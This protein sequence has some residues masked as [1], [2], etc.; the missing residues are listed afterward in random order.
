MSDNAPAFPPPRI[1]QPEECQPFDTAFRPARV[2]HI[3]DADT[4]DLSIDLGHDRAGEKVRIRL[5]GEAWLKD[6]RIGFNAWESRGD[7]RERGLLAKARVEELMPIGSLVMTR[8]FR[9]GARGSL[10]R[11]LHVVLVEV[12]DMGIVSL[13]D[14]LLHEGHGR[15]WWRGWS[16]GAPRPE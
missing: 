2:I 15:E 14:L 13:A 6:Q 11:W 10:Y 5:C 3:A 1:W 7:E 16:R 8:S 4:F 12:G 9:G